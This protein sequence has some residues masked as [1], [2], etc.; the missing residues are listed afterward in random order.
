MS[1]KI[2][3]PCEEVREQCFKGDS[4]KASRG[5]RGRVS[6][7]SFTIVTEL[8]L[9]SSDIVSYSGWFINDNNTLLHQLLCVK[10]LLI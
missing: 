1:S 8:L 10:T 2:D 6:L 9:I 5:G 3:T 7:H 4:P